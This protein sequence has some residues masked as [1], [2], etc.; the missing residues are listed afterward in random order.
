MPSVGPAKGLCHPEGDDFTTW[1]EDQK[2]W[3]A[4]LEHKPKS[5]NKRFNKSEK[6]AKQ[7]NAVSAS[8]SSSEDEEQDEHNK[9]VSPAPSAPG[10]E[11]SR[12]CCREKSQEKVRPNLSIATLVSKNLVHNVRWSKEVFDGYTHARMPICAADFKQM[13]TIVDR[14]VSGAPAFAACMR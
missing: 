13:E 2:A 12:G 9:N 6:V 7:L 8:A 10:K 1:A 4:P 5:K 11:R 3:Y 14:N